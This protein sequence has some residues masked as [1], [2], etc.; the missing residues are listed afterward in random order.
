MPHGKVVDLYLVNGTPSGIITATLSNWPAKAIK[1]DYEDLKAT[2]RTD[3]EQTGLYY[4]YDTNRSLL[5]SGTA[6]NLKQELLA[7]KQSFTT[8][9]LFVDLDTSKVSLQSILPIAPAQHLSEF[10][11]VIVEEI[12]DNIT[13]LTN[14]L[15]Y[16][17]SV[18]PV[19]SVQ[20]KQVQAEQSIQP[21]QA[22][23]VYFYIISA[24]AN[25]TAKET[26]EGFLVLKGSKLRETMA[27]S[28]PDK[29]RLMREELQQAG[30]L[31]D[32]ITQEDVLFASPSGA[33]A[34]VQGRSSN[35]K[36]EW[37]TQE[38]MSYKAYKQSK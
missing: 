30:K 10:Q 37:K 20:P 6:T 17:H 32:N 9:L 27:P 2:S 22:E 33:S 25:A 34:F 16:A 15:G 29:Y 12:Q 36:E 28:F 23:P 5:A 21:V 31:A 35:G 3:V 26:E 4:L 8:A 7:H 18:E 19:A 11:S 38:G 14:V 1:I 24:E 13:I